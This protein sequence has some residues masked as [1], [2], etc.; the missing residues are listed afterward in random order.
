MNKLTLLLLFLFTIYFSLFTLE[1]GGHLTEDTT[2]SPENNPYLVTSVLYV[3]QGVT[4]TIEPG[5]VVLLNAAYLSLDTYPEL[6]IFSTS[7]DKNAK[8]IFVNGKIIA[9]GTKDNPILFSRIQQDSTYFKWGIIHLSTT[10]ELSK[11][12]FCRFEHASQI[13]FNPGF[14]PYGAISAKQSFIVDNCEFVDN[15]FGIGV[16]YPDNG[17][18]LE[19]TNNRFWFDEGIEPSLQKMYGILVDDDLLKRYLIA[20][21]TFIDQTMGLGSPV[22]YTNNKHINT[23]ICTSLSMTPNSSHYIYKNH[24]INGTILGDTSSEETHK[25]YIRKNT[26]EDTDSIG[27][28]GI[29]LHGYGYFE[30]SDNIVHG[31]IEDTSLHSKGK[32]FNNIVHDGWGIHLGFYDMYNNISINNRYGLKSGWRL[33]NHYNNIYINNRYGLNYIT[34]FFRPF[35]NSIFIGNKYFAESLDTDT[36]FINNCIIDSINIAY[37]SEEFYVIGN[38]NIFVDSTQINDIFEDFANNNFHLMDGSIAIDAGLDIVDSTNH[39]YCNSFDLDNGYRVWDGD[40]D[41]IAKRDIGPYEYNSQPFGVITGQI[42]EQ[43]TGNPVDYVLLK[44]NNDPGVFEFTDSLGFFEIKLPAGTYSLHTERVF[45][46]DENV[47]NI[48]VVDGETT[49]IDF[50]MVSELVVGIDENN[51]DKLVVGNEYLEQNYPNPFNPRT[52]ISYQLPNHSFKSAKIVVYNL[53]GQQIWESTILSA[54]N[55]GHCVF[56]GSMFNSSIYFYSL[57]VDGKTV[58]TK[59]MIMIK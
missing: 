34:N 46:F 39:F 44:V 50:N 7:E 10:A 31:S 28:E 36:L 48:T 38:N 6:F 23:S 25:I 5:T 24:L 51:S 52:E 20:N 59:S 1:V 40:G 9:E 43:T 35:E 57:I 53:A 27:T 8:M 22:S 47:S 37:K 26:I 42:T 17:L 13:V 45:Y 18:K 2:W 12:K 55:N 54:Q 14:Q 15:H 3:D 4:L 49:Y 16:Y 33:R 21:N 32:V 11:F 56:D 58:S 29:E 30:V 41:G 19:I